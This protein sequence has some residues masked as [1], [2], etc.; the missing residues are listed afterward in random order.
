M[1]ACDCRRLE[2]M[3]KRLAHV[4]AQMAGVLRERV[5]SPAP[6]PARAPDLALDAFLD[7]A[8]AAAR[9]AEVDGLPVVFSAFLRADLAMI[10]VSLARGETPGS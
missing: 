8:Y 2:A 7:A 6:R 9:R 5:N 10:G 4:E 3:E 1:T